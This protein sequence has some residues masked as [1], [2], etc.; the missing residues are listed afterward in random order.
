MTLQNEEVMDLDMYAK[1]K[2]GQNQAQID[3]INPDYDF[4]NIHLAGSTQSALS[5][6]VIPQVPV[7][8]NANATSDFQQPAQM[9]QEQME[10]FQ[11]MYEQFLQLQQQDPNF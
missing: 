7:D 6:A 11:A 8:F 2:L 4:T 1:Q 9:D 3:Q 10:Q 5:G